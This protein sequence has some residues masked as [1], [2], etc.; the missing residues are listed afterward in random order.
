MSSAT[1]QSQIDSV[2]AAGGGTV[3]VPR[4]ITV[5]DAPLKLRAR[6]RLLGQGEHQT[7][8]RN[9]PSSPFFASIMTDGFEAAQATD[10]WNYNRGVAT[11]TQVTYDE[12]DGLHMGCMVEKLTIDGNKRGGAKGHGLCIFGGAFNVKNVAIFDCD[13]NGLWTQC[14]KPD[15]SWQGDAEYCFYNM[16]ESRIEDVDISNVTGHGVLYRGPN[17]SYMNQV[18]V[19]MAKMRGFSFESG[20]NYDAGGLKAG[21][22]HAYSCNGAETVMIGIAGMTCDYL[23]CDAP[24]AH[25]LSMWGRD[26]IIDTVK[27]FR[28]NRARLTPA[29]GIVMGGTNDSIRYYKYIDG[30]NLPLPTNPMQGGAL[31]NSG[32]NN[33]VKDGDVAATTTVKGVAVSSPT[34]V[35]GGGLR[36]W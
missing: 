26:T 30:E 10:Y 16:H 17:D 1:I 13:G 2:W 34:P 28:H 22:L 21:K 35:Y 32:T 25:G 14:G 6:V 19:K 31:K 12:D 27:V 33:F 20:A 11:G 3:W 29:W 24:A 15:N 23:C 36:G 18:Q 4:G 8:L 5:L 9:A 7:V